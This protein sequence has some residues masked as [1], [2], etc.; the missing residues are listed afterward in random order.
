[1]Y[2]T[3]DTTRCDPETVKQLNSAAINYGAHALVLCDTAGHVTPVGTVALVKFVLEEVVNPS[4]AKIRVD[5]HGH[6]DRGLATANAM[7]AL[8]AGADFVHPTPLGLGETVGHTQR[9][10]KLFHLEW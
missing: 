1:M 7:A 2:V 8:V 3:E 5:W 4:G 9:D 6:C 10:P